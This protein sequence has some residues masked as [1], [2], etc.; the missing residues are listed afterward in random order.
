MQYDINREPAKI[1]AFSTG[2]IQRYLTSKGPLPSDQ[3][4]IKEEAKLTYSSVGKAL[5]KLA[6]AT[7]VRVIKT[8]SRHK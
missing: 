7:E 2:K 3:I 5:E 1:S 4:Q 8:N 6:K